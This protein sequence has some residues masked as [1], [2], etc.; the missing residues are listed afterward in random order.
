MKIGV[1][2]NLEVFEIGRERFEIRIVPVHAHYLILQHDQADGDLEKQ[3]SILYDIMQDILEANG[4]EFKKDFWEKYS[5]YEGM[6][7]FITT[8]I[9]KDAKGKKKQQVA[10]V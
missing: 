8:S 5:D 9:A 7:E 4:Y 2:R 1:N 3:A 6:V 10:K